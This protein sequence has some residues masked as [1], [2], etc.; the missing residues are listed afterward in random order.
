MVTSAVSATFALVE[1]AHCQLRQQQRRISTVDLATAMKN[2]KKSLTI[3]PYGP[4]KGL[5]RLKYEYQGTTY[6][7]DIHGQRQ[8]TCWAEG[9]TFL[10]LPISPDREPY[11]K[12]HR[13]FLKE[14]PGNISNHNIFVV[15]QSGSMKLS[16]V[17]GA[18]NR[19]FAVFSSILLDYILESIKKKEANDG[20]DVI[21]I[22][23]MRDA[24]C[25]VLDQEPLDE[26]TY[27]KVI[28]LMKSLRPRGQGNYIPAFQKLCNML[29][30]PFSS[31][32]SKT[33]PNMLTKVRV[34]FLTDGRPSDQKKKIG[35]E[36]HSHQLSQSEWV[37][38][39]VVECVQRIASS[40]TNRC[41]FTFVSFG[42]AS[43]GKRIHDF[44]VKLRDAAKQAGSDAEAVD[45]E[46]STERLGSV[47]TSVSSTATAHCTALGRGHSLE[48][49][50][51]L[52]LDQRLPLLEQIQELNRHRRPNLKD[53][54]VLSMSTNALKR[55]VFKRRKGERPEA[56]PKGLK[57]RAA[58]GLA[59]L[60][61]PFAKGG[62]RYAFI[63]RE[64][65]G[66]SNPSTCRFVGDWLVAKQPSRHREAQDG[67][68][69][70]PW[71]PRHVHQIA[72]ESKPLS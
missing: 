71:F 72:E 8:L 18:R 68:K 42:A 5:E 4:N 3:T 31:R 61:R 62:E 28:G 29:V 58:D 25:V 45:A 9:M 41:S 26:L 19:H 59:L 1:D 46:T 20:H 57:Y 14:H 15:D 24:T 65:A 33:S 40:L 64:V 43:S 22:M 17:P 38:Q 48:P 49:R 37:L 44:L 34:V 12:E 52:A 36:L 63:A 30:R 51:L 53:F 21:T 10:E 66:S 32:G 67:S 55:V 27:N 70:S 69:S 2:G 11:L 23:A 35:S 7:T 60:K 39:R 13:N 50:R 47:L 56:V 54:D 6:I 16:D